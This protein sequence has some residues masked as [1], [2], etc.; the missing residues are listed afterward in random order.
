MSRTVQLAALI[1]LLIA[2]AGTVGC[3]G[4][5]RI[6][7]VPLNLRK[8]RDRDPLIRNLDAQRCYYWQDQ[9]GR[10]CIAMEF[11]NLSLIGDYG[12]RSLAMSLVLNDMPAGEARNY[13]VNLRTLR[14]IARAGAEHVRW[15]SLSGIFAVRRTSDDHIRGRFRIAAKQQKFH[16]ALGWSSD[17]RVLLFGELDA[18]PGER[19]GRE[20]LKRT[21]ADGMD[22]TTRTVDPKR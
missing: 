11:E 21:E 10:L 18:I 6:G 14:M 20:I 16:I 9:N 22:R 8:L 4:S 2:G 7:V 13:R 12:R 5:A 3:A 17:S 1:G 15:A 19:Q